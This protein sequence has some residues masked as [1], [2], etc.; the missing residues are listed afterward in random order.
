MSLTTR[1]LLL[2]LLALT[3]ALVIQGYNEVALRTSRDAAVRAD[4]LATVRGAAEDFTQLSERMRQA[5]DLISGDPSVRARDPA[6][7]E[8]YLKRS[9]VRLPHVILIALTDPGGRVICDSAGSAAGAYS[10]GARAYHRRALEADGFAVGG[11]ALGIVSKRPSIHFARVVSPADEAQ[12]TARDAAAT[13]VPA[14]GVLLAA[15]DLDWLSDHLEQ[16]LHQAETAITVTDHDGLIIA[17]RP[18]GADWIG[19]PIPPERAAMRT[20]GDGEVRIAEGLDGRTRI[21]ATAMPGGPLAG[22]RLVV[23]RDSAA[24]F[25]D[26]DAATR[27]GLVLIALGALLALAAALLAGRMFIRRPIDRLLRIAAAW[28]AGDLTVRTGLRGTTEFGR[29][30]GKLD[31]MAGTLQRNADELH[32]EIRRGRALQEQQVTMLHELN[33]RVKNT[34]A[35]VQAL[36]RQSRGSEGVLE[37]RILALSKTHD[38]LTREDWSGAS[39]RE[40]LESELSPYRTGGDQIGLDGP[41]ISLSPRHVLALGMTIHELTTNAAKYGSLSG[42]GGRVRVSW[43]LATTEG[44][45]PRL[46][47][48]WQESGGPPVQPPARAG[49]GTRLISG[50]VRRELDGSVDLA[51]EA[52]G[53]R[54]HLDV[55]LEPGLSAILAPTQ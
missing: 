41:D 44:G 55:P 27:R 32:A 10:S 38:L 31:A 28:Q 47:L 8:A 19:K 48:T 7:C 13:E 51:F 4:A 20:A 15:V 26:I 2:V 45:T 6:A 36:A 43:S 1:I 17:Q 23:G 21:I 29:L 52:K 14:T 53:L 22:V 34:L 12:E 30:G 5:L 3:P 25:A 18:N 9:A 16:T 49:F 37:A 35:T 24:A 54:C 50:G 11:Y 46:R 42:P 33:H 39:L 40:V